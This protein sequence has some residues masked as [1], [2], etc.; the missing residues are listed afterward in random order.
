MEGKGGGVPSE[1]EPVRDEEE[2]QQRE[3]DA[4][5]GRQLHRQVRR[6]RVE[7]AGELGDAHEAEQLEEAQVAQLLGVAAR[8]LGEEEDEAE[9]EAR[10]REVDDEE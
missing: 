9:G 7:H 3:D 8:A 1:A 6:E 2:A 10:G 4:R 5:D